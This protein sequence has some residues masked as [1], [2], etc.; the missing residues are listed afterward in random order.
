MSHRDEVFSD[1]SMV[2]KIYG[3]AVV[4]VMSG[5]RALV[6]QALQ[7]VALSGL[8][9]DTDIMRNPHV[10]FARTMLAMETIYW[11]T[12]DEARKITA[13]IESMHRNVRGKVGDNAGALPAN[14]A[15]SAR[16]PRLQQ[17]VLASIMD[18]AVACY[19]QF[20]A[21][22]TPRQKDQF[23]REYR[24]V[25]QL[26]GLPEQFQFADYQQLTSYMQS[27]YDTFGDEDLDPHVR[28]SITPAHRKVAI[29]T[30][31]NLMSGPLSPF[32]ALWLT[33]VKGVLPPNV[34]EYVSLSWTATDA[35]LFQSMLGMT[36]SS[37]MLVRFT[38]TLLSVVRARASST[39][40]TRWFAPLPS[41]ARKVVARPTSGPLLYQR[42]RMGRAIQ[43]R[44]TG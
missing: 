2:R 36:A 32:R 17:W 43:G 13:R 30:N 24:I 1:R 25:T 10:R 3:V 41:L 21:P 29:Q 35:Q 28:L 27:M 34:R 9:K 40:L 26:F 5:M 23:V 12:W 38:E 18:S 33:A 22:L 11:G 44:L 7:P 20:V 39:P 8:L 31:A 37:L 15:Y 16:D 4:N 42:S 6:L 14:T 19:E